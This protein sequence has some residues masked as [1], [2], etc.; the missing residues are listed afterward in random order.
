MNLNSID[1]VLKFYYIYTHGSVAQLVERRT[2]N[3]C[4]SSSNLLGA[5]K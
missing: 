2:E 5:T 1:K 4:V 3:P